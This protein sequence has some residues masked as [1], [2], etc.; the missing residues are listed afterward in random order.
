MPHNTEKMTI[1]LPKRVTKCLEI[2]S[3]ETSKTKN[4]I[5]ATAIDYFMFQLCK[6]N[7]ELL[8]QREETNNA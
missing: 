2:V 3:G 7:L 8:N 4:E 1:E 6:Q 5:I